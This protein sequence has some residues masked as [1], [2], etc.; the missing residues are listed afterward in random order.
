LSPELKSKTIKVRIHV[1]LTAEG[2]WYALGGSG[3][4]EVAAKEEAMFG[5]LADQIQII[6][7][8]LTIPKK[9]VTQ[10]TVVREGKGHKNDSLVGRCEL[11]DAQADM[12]GNFLEDCPGVPP[13]SSMSD[14]P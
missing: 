10:G 4:E 5:G 6:E 12:K 2:D 11:C 9:K 3:I 1:G 8:E 13:L 14:L 7:A